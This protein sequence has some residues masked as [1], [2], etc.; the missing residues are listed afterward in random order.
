MNRVFLGLGSNL[1][2]RMAN[3]TRAIEC[4]Q[5]NDMIAIVNLSEFR[6]S[7][8][9]NCGPQPDYLNAAIEISTFLTPDELLDATEKIETEMGRES[10]GLNDPRIIDIDILFYNN[11]IVSTERLSIP[12]PLAHERAFV[13]DPMTDL[14][15]SFKHPALEQTMTELLDSLQ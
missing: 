9:M 10:K 3:M 15:P 12:H 6:E 13:L 8:P 2:N 4:L 11:D 7:A 5:K 14:A 1:G